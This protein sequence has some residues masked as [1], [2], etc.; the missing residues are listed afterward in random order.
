MA[1]RR[2]PASLGLEMYEDDADMRLRLQ[3]AP[4]GTL[5]LG[6]SDHESV[7]SAPP[8]D[9]QQEAVGATLVAEASEDEEDEEDEEAAK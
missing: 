4:D 2:A 3:E 9:E 6:D 5:L 8:A 1:L 7:S